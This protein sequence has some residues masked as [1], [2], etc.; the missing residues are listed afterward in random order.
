VSAADFQ[1][2]TR[3]M[4]RYVLA[5]WAKEHDW[6]PLHYS[7]IVDQAK[8]LRL[9]GAKVIVPEGESANRAVHTALKQLLKKG[10]VEDAGFV[11]RGSYR[12]VKGKGR[13][14]TDDGALIARLEGTCDKA[15][16]RKRYPR[17][18]TGD[19]VAM[20]PKVHKTPEPGA[21]FQCPYAQGDRVCVKYPMTEGE[22]EWFDATVLGTRKERGVWEIQVK[23]DLDGLDEWINP[24]TTPVKSLPAKRKPKPPEAP[25]IPAQPPSVR[26]PTPHQPRPRDVK[27]QNKPD[28]SEEDGSDD[29]PIRPGPSGKP[30]PQPGKVASE[31]ASSPTPGG[32]SNETETK[33]RVCVICIIKKRNHM[34]FPCCHT[35][36]CE[37]C[38]EKGEEWMKSGKPCP[39]CNAPIKQIKRVYF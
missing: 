6:I 19:G 5:E 34:C 3:R 36:F 20:K 37:D 39:L 17:P 7:D 4:C 31:E 1:D 23:Y 22:D 8:T 16:K 9:K 32:N 25:P 29:A 14:D 28:T 26:P 33:D 13:G 18:S 38:V 12:I 35:A 24:A 11:R 2:L 30:K 27:R 15:E 10:I 21:N